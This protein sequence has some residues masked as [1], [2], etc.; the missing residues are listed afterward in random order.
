MNS[1]DLM[2]F[3]AVAETGGIGRAAA[4]LNTV[5]S[6]VTGRIRALEQA[7]RV[8]LF[9][10][11]SRGVTLTR[12]GERLLPYALQVGQLLAEARHALLAEGEPR[13]PLRIGAMETTAAL[14]LPGPLADFA[15]RH[16]EVD[17]EL[18]TGPT[19]HLIAR[20]LDRSLEGAFV[21]GPV[22][23]ADLAGIP[24][25][26]EELV[27]VAHP[28]VGDL[29][30]L[31]D[32]LARARDA[33]VLVFRAGC[34]YRRRLEAFLA[35]Q[36]LVHVR[37]MEFGTLDGILGCVAAGLGVTLVPR[38]VAEPAHR[39]GRVSVHPVPDGDGHVPTLLVHRADDR[40]SAAFARFAE[41]VRTALPDVT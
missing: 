31:L 27:L 21:A 40:P 37:R 39:A 20:V 24:V 34:S 25:F 22:A 36:G 16:P 1:T 17:I 26:T 6:N 30:A 41:Q 2:F 23:Q 18:E 32:R 14:R 29:A 10:R 9:H 38:A 15:A 33:K 12:A 5:Q 4:R 7:L 13:G 19:E 28:A 35:R 3:A 8:P 11:G